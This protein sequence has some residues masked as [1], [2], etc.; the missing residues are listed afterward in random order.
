MIDVVKGMTKFSINSRMTS[1]LQIAVL[2]QG[3]GQFKFHCLL[4]PSNTN[5]VN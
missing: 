3:N 2:L 4:C 1:D 5:H